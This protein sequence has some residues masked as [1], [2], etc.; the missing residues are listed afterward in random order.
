MGNSTTIK[1]DLTIPHGAIAAWA[2][3]ND[4]DPAAVDVKA[5]LFQALIDTTTE[6]FYTD[7][8]I[9]E[10]EAT[11]DELTI[12]I[13]GNWASGLLDDLLRDLAGHGVRGRITFPEEH[14]GYDLDN[15]AVTCIEAELMWPDEQAML[16]T[17]AAPSLGTHQAIYTHDRPARRGMATLLERW[18]GQ[19]STAGDLDEVLAELVAAGA[20][21]T[22]TTVPFNP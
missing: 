22:R 9:H 4:L 15:N 8:S 21:V 16:I 11:D 2:R 17:V 6:N 14:W 18:R 20:T 7:D 5:E 1:G 3:A 10:I 13:D 19:K 12:S